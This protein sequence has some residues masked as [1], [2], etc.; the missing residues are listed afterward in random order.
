[1]A[2]KKFWLGMLVMIL[3]FG[4]TAAGCYMAT[5]VDAGVDDSPITAGQWIIGEIKSRNAIN[6]YSFEANSSRTYSLFWD[7]SAGAN[8][9][10]Y[11]CDIHVTVFRSNSS[12]IINGIEDEDNAYNTPKI[13][14]GYT[15]T[16]YIRI[17]SHY[18]TFGTEDGTP[19]TASTGTYAVR[20]TMN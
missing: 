15:G 4:M 8:S 11:T 2:V 12:T 6:W 1:M 9:G 17:K 10:N 19:G 14:S 16:V 13:I 7:D 20:Y 3:V 18:G 5:D